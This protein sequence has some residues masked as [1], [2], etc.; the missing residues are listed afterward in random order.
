MFFY[1]KRLVSLG[2]SGDHSKVNGYGQPRAV[3]RRAESLGPERPASLPALAITDQ[4]WISRL[5]FNY[6]TSC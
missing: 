4:F 3:R 5:V 2:H 1:L 6:R